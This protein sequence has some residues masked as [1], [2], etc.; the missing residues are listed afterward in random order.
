MPDVTEVLSL[1]IAQQLLAEEMLLRLAY[2]GLDGAPRVI[3]IGYLWDGSQFLI[4]TIPRAAKVRALRADPRVAITI[5]VL[6][7]PPRVLLAR[8]RAELSTVDGVP[9]GYLQA[10]HRA[11]PAETWDD[12]DAQVRAL[13]E[14]MVAITITPDWAKLLD[15][16]T[17]MPSAV[18]QLIQERTGQ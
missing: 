4:W 6:G 17:T 10:S 16:E 11:I 1:P 8:G 5:D 12:F 15:F 13:Y 2:T 14:Q 3:P 7:P 9:D 18:E